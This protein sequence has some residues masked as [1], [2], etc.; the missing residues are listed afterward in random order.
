MGLVLTLFPFQSIAYA[1]F[2]TG[3]HSFFKVNRK[4]KEDTL[5]TLEPPT[6]V[7]SREPVTKTA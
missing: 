2:V 3:I 4:E 5:I 6:F 7:F 1:I